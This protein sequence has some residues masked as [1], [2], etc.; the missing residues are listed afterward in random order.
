MLLTFTVI[1]CSIIVRWLQ[2]T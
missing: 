1:G 2:M